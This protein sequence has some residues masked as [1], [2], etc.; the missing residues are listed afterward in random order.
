MKG[1]RG[2]GRGA[3]D[4]VAVDDHPNEIRYATEE[5]EDE[6]KLCC[7]PETWPC[8]VVFIISESDALRQQT[9]GEIPSQ[10]GTR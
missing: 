3:G 8:S 6:V 9:R 7:L 4:L 2:R 10:T 1:R 5:Q